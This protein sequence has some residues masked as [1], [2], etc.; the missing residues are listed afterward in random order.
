MKVIII[1]D[2]F[3][4]SLSSE[5]I[6]DIA[7]KGVNKHFND[8][9]VVKIPVA[10]GGEGTVDCFYKACGGEIITVNSTGPY[11]E[12]IIKDYLKLGDKAIIEMAKCAGLPMVFGNE[13]PAITTTF[14]VGTQILKAI[15]NGAK[16]IILGLG[17]SATNDGGCGAA[18]ALGV[19]FYDDKGREFIPVGK[20]LK[21]IRKIDTSNSNKLLKDIKVEVMCDID[22][23]LYGKTGAA[24]IFAPQK[25]ANEKMV[26]MLDA[27]LVNLCDIIKK[28][29]KVDVSNLA[30][31]GA[32]GGFGAGVAAFFGAELRA[33][34]DVVL[35]TVE[36]EKKLE[37]CSFV[38]TGEGRLDSQSLNGKVPIGVAR[39][40]KKKNVPVIAI[41]GILG[42]DILKVYEY[43]ISSVFV[44][45]R[46]ALPFKEVIKTAKEDYISTLDDVLKL[47]KIKF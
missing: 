5:E 29:C 12:E 31:G 45:N 47:M 6:A 11:N 33:G 22:N 20:T 14:G 34:I 35:E 18:V 13:N 2:S 26:E 1:S 15:E 4:G 9:E 39:A 43:G 27:G 23:V 8:C 46:K 32:A 30:G 41:V 42:D 36:F 25:G 44:T 37:N 40:A 17:G 10:D 28:D 7:Q 3:K 19:K 21:N 16:H 38:I 24:Y